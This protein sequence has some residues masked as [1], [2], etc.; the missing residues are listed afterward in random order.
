MKIRWRPQV[1]LLI[2]GITS[3]GVAGM[4]IEQWGV[5][6]TAIAALAGALTKLVEH[7]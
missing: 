7:D 1:L 2:T 3:M 6:T 4:V 5:T